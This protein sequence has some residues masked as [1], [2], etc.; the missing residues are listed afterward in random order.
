MTAN[1]ALGTPVFSRTGA[2]RTLLKSVPEY[3]TTVYIADNGRNGERQDL[4]AESWPFDLNILQLQ[5]DC[6]IGP[7][8]K[9]IAD[10]VTEPY[11][12]MC[13]ND[14]EIIREMDLL[15]L[16]EVLENNPDL[17]GIATWLK[18]GD[19]IRTGARNLYEHNGTIIK[20][21][22]TTPIMEG[23]ILP[24][25]RFEFIPQCAL[26]R[27]EIFNTYTYDP[28][29]FNSE[30]IDFFYGQKEADEWDFAST[31]A[32]LIRHHRNI[33]PVY[34]QSKRGKNHVDFDKMEQKWGFDYALPGPRSDWVTTTEQSLPNDCFD[35]FRQLT[36]P[37]V[38]IPTRKLLKKL[39]L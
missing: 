4:Y 18:E 14:M 26:Y 12:F 37:S 3:V 15:R 27:S 2:L 28:N 8:R 16:Q 13:D 20:N 6:G 29:I 19:T 17:G 35:L 7:C 30:H 23:K 9:A 31:P 22:R 10:A 21:I 1:I 38:W 11:L 36:P 32:V 24:F 5:Y 33:D 39:G 25:A 34:R